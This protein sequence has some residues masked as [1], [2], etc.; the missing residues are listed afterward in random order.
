MWLVCVRPLGTSW[1]LHTN[2]LH[3]LLQGD[4]RMAKKEFRLTQK[5]TG[6]SGKMTRG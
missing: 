1:A 4:V 5:R 2:P 6:S 3:V